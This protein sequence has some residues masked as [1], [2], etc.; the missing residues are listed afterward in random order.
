[1]HFIDRN[2]LKLSRNSSKIK[3]DLK[4]KPNASLQSD[5]AQ[6]GSDDTSLFPAVRAMNCSGSLCIISTP[7]LSGT[8]FSFYIVGLLLIKKNSF[9]WIRTFKRLNVCFIAFFF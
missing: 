6:V 9:A 4:R 2:A 8:Y 3:S 5:T 7:L 1:M